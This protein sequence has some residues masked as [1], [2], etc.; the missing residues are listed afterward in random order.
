M[1]R[2]RSTE[3]AGPNGL[4]ART[5]DGVTLRGLHLS[6]GADTPTDHAV[7]VAHGMTNATARVSTR[8]VLARFANRTAVVALDFRG[9]GRSDGRSSVGR[10]EILDVDAAIGAAR[11]LGYTRVT[12]VGFSL[13][14]AVALR[15]AGRTRTDPALT[16]AADAVVAVSPPAR[17]FLRESRSMLRVQW[18][19]E[20]PVGPFLGPRLGIRLGRP[21]STVPSTPL[22][23]VSRIAPTP[24]LFVHGTADHYFGPEQSVRLHRAA[25]GAE[26]WL[27][28]GMGHAESGIAATTVDRILDWSLRQPTSR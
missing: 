27:V 14:A 25:P 13:G 17:W 16:E 15:H 3:H 24:L 28:D 8:A 12:L 2:R 22:D 7:V 18:L 21:W 6:G 4:T 9:H 1:L 20:H 26:L 23:E 5:A 10:D 19:L 11:G